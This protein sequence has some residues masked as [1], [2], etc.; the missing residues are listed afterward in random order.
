MSEK[1][2]IW[3]VVGG[4]SLLVGWRT[5]RTGSDP[6]PQLVGIGAAGIMLL[7]TAEIAP[8]LASG[9]AVLLGISLAY[10]WDK[11]PTVAQKPLGLGGPLTGSPTSPPSGG[12]GGGGGAW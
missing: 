11:L 4:A 10:N 1:R 3:T 6:I 12:S 8:K 5:I 7:F 2:I 9:L